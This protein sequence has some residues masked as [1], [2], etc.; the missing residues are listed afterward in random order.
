MQLVMTGV[1]VR[2]P[3]SRQ[4]VDKGLLYINLDFQ[5]LLPDNIA[6]KDMQLV[7]SAE[8]PIPTEIVKQQVQIKSNFGEYT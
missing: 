8:N 3:L 4:E 6:I 1:S 2:V 7:D 5:F